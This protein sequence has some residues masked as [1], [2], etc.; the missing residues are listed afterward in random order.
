[1][2]NQSF[3]LNPVKPKLHPAF[4]KACKTPEG[5]SLQM[6]TTS[7]IDIVI[8]W[9]HPDGFTMQWASHGWN[10]NHLHC[11]SLGTKSVFYIAITLLQRQ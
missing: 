9:V 7:V 6:G 11:D 4:L 8:T 3:K 2:K 1:M 10:R 5:W